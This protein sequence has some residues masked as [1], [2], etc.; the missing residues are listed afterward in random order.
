MPF[1]VHTLTGRSYLKDLKFRR[2][3]DKYLSQNPRL[4]FR[5][6][7]LPT[8]IRLMVAR[9]VMKSHISLEFRWLE[10]LPIKRCGAFQGLD[11]LTALAR[12]SRQ[13]NV[14]LSNVI[15]SINTF[16]F[17]YFITRG[18]EVSSLRGL[19]WMEQLKKTF[20]F[21][22]LKTPFKQAPSIEIDFAVNVETVTAVSKITNLIPTAHFKV[23]DI[24]WQ[25]TGKWDHIDPSEIERFCERWKRLTKELAKDDVGCR[26]RN[27]RLHPLFYVQ[28]TE[29]AKKK[30][31]AAGV[32]EAEKW[33]DEGL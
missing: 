2:I 29:E 14:E 17:P 6:M 30:L 33:I 20:E 23:F 16:S 32:T 13:N 8:E 22:L 27:W 26:L 31:L 1:F 9:Y 10:D 25:Y 3:F 18:L 24:N 28:S 19:P 12:T 7:D 5:F 4:P 21:L 11:S 15:W